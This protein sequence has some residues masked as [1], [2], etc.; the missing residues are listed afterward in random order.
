MQG[1][2][3]EQAS[4]PVPLF[5]PL[6]VLRYFDYVFT[7]VFTFEMVIKVSAGMEGP[8]A[9]EEGRAKGR[10]AAGGDYT[11]IKLEDQRRI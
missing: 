9:H 2:L 7:G 11:D 3:L 5:C 8:W 4:E 6:K 10:M 1:V